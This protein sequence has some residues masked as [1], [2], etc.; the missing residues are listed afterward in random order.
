M[1][2]HPRYTPSLFSVHFKDLH[3]ALQRK[4]TSGSDDPSRRIELETTDE[5]EEH[6]TATE[7]DNDIGNELSVQ[8]FCNKLRSEGISEDGKQGV[9]KKLF[10]V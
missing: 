5:T 3:A 1:F 4:S 8:E 2:S 10:D 7:S 9:S 6:E